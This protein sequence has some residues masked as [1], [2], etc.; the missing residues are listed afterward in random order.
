MKT[1]RL[2]TFETNSSSTHSLNVAT[3]EEYKRWEN[4]ELLYDEYNYIFV[5]NNEENQED[6][7]CKTMEGFFNSYLESF[8]EK[9]TSKSGD[10]IV[11][12]GKYGFD[13]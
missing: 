3:E 1:I 12:F 13:G 10:K 4:E 7:S 6:E 2:G 5:E 8:E 11:I 9:Y